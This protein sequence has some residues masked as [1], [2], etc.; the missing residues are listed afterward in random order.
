MFLRLTKNKRGVRV[1]K[2]FPD[3]KQF[4]DQAK[5]LMAS[6]HQQRSVQVEENREER[7]QHPKY[8][9]CIIRRKRKK[10]NVMWRIVLS[11]F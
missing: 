8:R 3:L 4:V 5:K 11:F 7:K 6:F 10:K 1:H 2:Y 9:C